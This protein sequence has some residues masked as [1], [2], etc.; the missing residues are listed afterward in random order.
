MR[1][2]HAG[3]IVYRVSDGVTK[4]LLV[5]PKKDRPREWVLPKGHIENGEEPDEA[6]LREVR[7][8]AGVTARIACPLKTLEFEVNEKSVR[9]AIY[10]MELISQSEPEEKRRC[11]WFS[12]EDAVSH[13]THADVKALLKE[14]AA[15]VAATGNDRRRRM[16]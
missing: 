13:A 3:G 4:F 7:E 2:T 6:A 8:E 10:L 11:K 9:M 1:P 16:S 5:G 14:A 15:R 12:F